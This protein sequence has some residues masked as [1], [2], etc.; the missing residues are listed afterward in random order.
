MKRLFESEGYDVDLAK[1]GTSGLELIRKRRLSAILLDRCLPA[2][3]TTCSRAANHRTER[4]G[5]CGGQSRAPRNG[6][7]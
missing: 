4:K 6:C 5:G 7:T 2:N 3:H 1:D